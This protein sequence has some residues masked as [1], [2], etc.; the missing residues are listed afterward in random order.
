MS[1]KNKKRRKNNKSG[2]IIINGQKAFEYCKVCGDKITL[3]SECLFCKRR[4]NQILIDL[5]VSEM[6]E[7]KTWV[8][9][10]QCDASYSSDLTRCPSCT[11][12][13]RLALLEDLLYKKEVIKFEDITSGDDCIKI[14]KNI[15]KKSPNF[16]TF[17]VF[18]SNYMLFTHY[19]WSFLNDMLKG[20]IPNTRVKIED[21]LDYI[22]DFMVYAYSDGSILIDQINNEDGLDSAKYEIDIS[23][24]SA[25][26]Q[27]NFALYFHSLNND[28][29]QCQRILAR[30]M[31]IHRQFYPIIMEFVEKYDCNNSDLTAG[32]IINWIAKKIDSAKLVSLFK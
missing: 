19:T 29:D 14:S 28:E 25:A 26:S 21:K 23:D 6:V 5:G 27:D 32:Q 7:T 12:D 8:I 1:K 30:I 31:D 17:L 3:G 11:E 4:E 24:K 2:N 22:S 15:L 9:C 20:V 10:D 18:V 16:R 13:K